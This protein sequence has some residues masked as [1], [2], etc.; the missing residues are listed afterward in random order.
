MALTLARGSIRGLGARRLTR[1]LSARTDL[2]GDLQQ[3]SYENY[4]ETSKT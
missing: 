1:G 4:N 3:S 2:D